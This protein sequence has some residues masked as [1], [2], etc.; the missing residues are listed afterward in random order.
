MPTPASTLDL[1]T[2]RAV[3]FDCYGT[4]IDWEEGIRAYVAPHLERAAKRGSSSPRQWVA[5]WEPIQFAMLSPYRSYREI[6][7]EQLR[8]HDAVTSSSS[9]SPTSDPAWR[10]P[11]ASGS[12]R[13]HRPVAAPDRQRRRLAIVSNID[14]VCSPRPSGACSRRSRSSSPPRTRAPTSPTP[15]PS[16]WPSSASASRPSRSCTP[17]LDGSTTS[18]RRARSGCAPASSIGAARVRPRSSSPPRPRGP[19]AGL[20]SPTSSPSFLPGSRRCGKNLR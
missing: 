17:P 6:L 20:R 16:G 18:V 2:I 4:L 8:G 1:S 13:R 7:A 19:L 5:R 12:L 15:R 14:R 11:S 3:S 9:P 10:G